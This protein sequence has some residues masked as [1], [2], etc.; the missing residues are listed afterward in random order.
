[1]NILRKKLGTN[2]IHNSLKK[3]NTLGLT[4]KMKGLNNENTEEIN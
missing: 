1:M 3:L 4:K 2:S